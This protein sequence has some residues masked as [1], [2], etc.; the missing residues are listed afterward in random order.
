ML[1][2]HGLTDSICP[3]TPPGASSLT[4]GRGATS[5]IVAS[6]AYMYDAHVVTLSLG[7]G[8]HHAKNTTLDT[9]MLLVC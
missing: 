2:D 1:Q 7:Y 9:I 8:Q 5:N 3:N 6:D 4:M